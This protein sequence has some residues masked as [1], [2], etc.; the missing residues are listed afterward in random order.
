MGQL[1]PVLRKVEGGF[2]HWC[3]GCE[4][5]HVICV[6]DAP[7]FGERWTFDGNVDKPTFNPSVRIRL[8]E[9][10]EVVSCCH[11]YLE[12]GLLKYCGDTTHGLSERTIPLPDLPGFL[13]D[14]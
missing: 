7:S 11:Y 3:P 1:S 12:S 14:Q 6:D 8:I 5:M 4:Q 13:Q 2:G 10:N 9:G